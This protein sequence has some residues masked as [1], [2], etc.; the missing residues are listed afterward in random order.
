MSDIVNNPDAVHPL[1]LHAKSDNDLDELLPL[2]SPT[3]DKYHL[4]L[5][6]NHN[7]NRKNALRQMEQLDTEGNTLTQDFL[8]LFEGQER[9]A[10]HGTSPT[11][12]ISIQSIVL[13]KVQEIVL[14]KA[15]VS[16]NHQKSEVR[17]VG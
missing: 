13:T 1:E 9:D 4:D 3:D 12:S 16:Q 11:N 10:Y 6:Q 8:S 14:R 2:A 5:G 17:I 15:K 7:N